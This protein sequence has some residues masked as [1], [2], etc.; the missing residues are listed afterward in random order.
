MTW[1]TGGPQTLIVEKILIIMEKI[2]LICSNPL[3]T[4]EKTNLENPGPLQ[5]LRKTKGSDHIREILNPYEENLIME[6]NGDR[7]WTPVFPHNSANDNHFFSIFFR[8]LLYQQDN[9]F[10]KK[11]M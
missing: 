8:Y 2:G 1:P 6:R 7:S 3:I 10:K 9:S 4:Q 11:E 5:E